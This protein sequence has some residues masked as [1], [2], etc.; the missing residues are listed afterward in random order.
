MGKR[1]MR[2]LHAIGKQDNRIIE[3]FGIDGRDDRRS[4]A[5]ASASELGFKLN[6]YESLDMFYATEGKAPEGCRDSAVI[7]TSPLSH[8]SIIKDCLQRD[9]NVFTELNLVSDG[10]DENIA[11]AKDR[12][13]VLFLSSTPI[14][15]DE[16]RYISGRVRTAMETGKP[17]NYT[18]HVGQYLPD[19]HPWES[20]KDF[21]IGQKRTNGCREIMTVELPWIVRAFGDIAEVHSLSSRQTGLDIDFN[22]CYNIQ[23]RHKNGN[24]GTFTADVVSR[25]PVRALRVMGEEIFLTW[26]GAPDGLCDYDLTGKELKPVDLYKT[27]EHREGYNPLIIENM[28]QN[29]LSEFLSVL[30]GE[31]EPI[32]SFEDD[33]VILEWIDKIETE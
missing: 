20:Y 28:Y 15:R 1:R 17:L 8:A 24:I 2:L 18:Y 9:M 3:L 26:N 29:E 10:Y 5:S 12:G 31:K 32:Y 7:S 21:F 25:V 19:W 22:D 23:I 27:T 14:Y 11:L 4:E 30:D 16:I 13:L 6:T 33:K